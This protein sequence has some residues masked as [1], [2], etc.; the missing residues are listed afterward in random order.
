L[1]ASANALQTKIWTAAVVGV[2]DADAGPAA[3][4]LLLSALNEMFDVSTARLNALATHPPAIV[5]W[6]LLV[7]AS[8]AA[9]FAGLAI[10]QAGARRRL[11]SVAFA[12]GIAGTVFVTIDIEYPRQGFVRIDAH[13]QLLLDARAA[14]K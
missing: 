8:V 9:L 13:D 12:V 7:I 14:M 10:G 4:N 5:Y 3:A 2:R 6:M 1:F 11:H